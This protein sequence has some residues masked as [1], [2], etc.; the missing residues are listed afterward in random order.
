MRQGQ[1]SWIDLNWLAGCPRGSF[2][3]PRQLDSTFATTADD[4]TLTDLYRKHPDAAAH[5]SYVDWEP[6]GYTIP[7]AP[8][9]E[10]LSE[11]DRIDLG[12]MC[13][14]VLHLLGQ[15]LGSIGLLEERSGILFSGM[16]SMTARWSTTCP[17][18]TRT[19]T[20][21]PWSGCVN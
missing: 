2:V 4:S 1:R 16:L 8:L 9:I 10:V 20:A 7:P 3:F 6:E 21:G 5:A 19:N 13:Y 17:D 18:A 12:D 11:G 15:S 14:R